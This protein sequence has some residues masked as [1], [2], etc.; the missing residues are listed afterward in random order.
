M[1]SGLQKSTIWAQK[2]AFVLYYN[3]ITIYITTTQSSLLLQNLMGFLLQFMELGYYVW[4][5]DIREN[6]TQCNLRSHD[7]FLQPW[8][9]MQLKLKFN[10]D[11][12]LCI[13]WI[14]HSVQRTTQWREAIN[15]NSVLV[16]SMHT[17][18]Y[19][20]N[21]HDKQHYND[22]RISIITQP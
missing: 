19:H 22:R 13:C 17:W 7:R 11:S 4:M 9:H 6:I 8:S 14:L 3:F 18:N 16:N 5:K 2:I 12:L 15:F 1:W 10:L 21:N 20:D